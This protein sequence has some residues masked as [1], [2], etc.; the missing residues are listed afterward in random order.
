[1]GLIKYHL[2]MFR[3]DVP[4]VDSVYPPT[5]IAAHAYKAP[6]RGVT[7]LLPTSVSVTE[8]AR[9]ITAFSARLFSLCHEER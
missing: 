5:A 3:Y 8:I 1:M 4:L 7:S 6:S 2:L 9:L